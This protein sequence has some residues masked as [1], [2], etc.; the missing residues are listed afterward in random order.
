MATR[1]RLRRAAAIVGLSLLLTGVI[2]GTAAGGPLTWQQVWE[3]IRPLLSDPGTIN[4]SD[5]PVHWTKLRGVPAGLADGL[6]NG[7]D[8]AG[9]GLKKNLVP[10]LE[11]AVDPAKIQR[12]VGGTCPAG[13]AVRSIGADGTV[14]CVNA[15]PPVVYFG[16]DEAEGGQDPIG[17]DWSS[18]GGALDLPAGSFSLVAKLQV[19]GGHDGGD[20]VGGQLDWLY[21]QLH[22]WVDSAS[23]TR[24]WTQVGLDRPS[25]GAA[26]LPITLTGVFSSSKPWR[27][28]MV[29]KDSWDGSSENETDV[30]W[31]NVHITATQVSQ[32]HEQQL[33]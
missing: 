6:D 13:Q 20:D 16:W 5:N 19:Q 7:V 9:F 29:C 10:N 14:A 1:T 12:R 11:F 32:L 25:Q 22:A 4:A 21:C 27:A 28:A 23:H 30:S 2:A 8:R 17:N 31:E 18:V 24:D 33:G 3:Q 26:T 15:A